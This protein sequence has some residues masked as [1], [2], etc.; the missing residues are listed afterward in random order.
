[1]R[2][3]VSLLC[4]LL[5]LA[6]LGA[7]DKV[8]R[9]FDPPRLPPDD[10][11]GPPR[12]LDNPAPF[13]PTFPTREAWEQRARELRTQVM[14][15]NGIWPMPERAPLQPVIHGRIDRDD[16]TVEKVYFESHPGLYVT[17]SL[18]RPKGREGKRPTVIC[19]HGHWANGRFHDH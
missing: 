17:G 10:R 11:L 1:M 18:Y 2:Y 9:V 6:T 12:H 5:A 15:A 4:L 19:P 3:A 7:D 16:Y 8:S 14:V 13:T